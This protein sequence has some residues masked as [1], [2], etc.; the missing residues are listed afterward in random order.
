MGTCCTEAKSG[1]DVG[2]IGLDPYTQKQ[3][4]EIPGRFCIS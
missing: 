4:K 1:I 2:I 3:I